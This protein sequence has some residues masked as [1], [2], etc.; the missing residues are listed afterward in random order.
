MDITQSFQNSLDA[1]GEFLPRAALFLV[2]LIVGWF[3]A[4][5]I[6]KAIGKILGKV[7]LDKVAD[8]A[9][10][11]RFTGKYTVSQLMGRLVYFALVLVVLQLSFAVFGPNPVSDLLNNLVAWLPHLFVAAVLIVIGMAIANVVRE[12]ISGTLENTSYGKALGMAAQ[13]AIVAIVAVAAFAQIGVATVVLVP[14]LWTVLAMVAGVV[15]VGVG[16]GLIGPM[17]SRW[18]RALNAAEEEA[19]KMKEAAA[20]SNANTGEGPMQSDYQSSNYEAAMDTQSEE[21]R[22]R[23]EQ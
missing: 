17:R 18:E 10:L 3:I 6:G 7:G 11:R 2:I 9:E 14:I 23:T 19:P 12:L 20:S 13:V 15:I 4:K 8:R 5:M 21:I 22:H 16:G 1:L